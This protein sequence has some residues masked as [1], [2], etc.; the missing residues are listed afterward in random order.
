MIRIGIEPLGWAC[1]TL[2]TYPPRYVNV[3][4][5]GYNTCAK[6]EGEFSQGAYK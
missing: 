5:A 3:H 6:W 1:Q 4:S 2:H